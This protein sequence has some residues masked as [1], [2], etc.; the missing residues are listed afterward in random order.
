[1]THGI[2]DGVIVFHVG[3]LNYDEVSRQASIYNTTIYVGG[4]PEI[5]GMLLIQPTE[6][7]AY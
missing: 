1:M 3:R 4:L 5:T 2:S 7:Y 6:T